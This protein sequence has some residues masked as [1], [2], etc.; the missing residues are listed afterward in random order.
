MKIIK[1]AEGLALKVNL[2]K[3]SN[4]TGRLYSNSVNLVQ[5]ESYESYITFDFL[6]ERDFSSPG[7]QITLYSQWTAI[8][9]L[10]IE[11]GIEVLED[12]PTQW[13]S[14]VT[15]ST[16]EENLNDQL[17]SLQ[18]TLAFFFPQT[19]HVERLIS[20]EKKKRIIRD[21]ENKIEGMGQD[22]E[23][24]HSPSMDYEVARQE[25]VDSQY[26]KLVDGLN[27]VRYDRALLRTDASQT[28]RDTY[29]EVT[30]EKWLEAEKVI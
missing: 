17:T 11:N 13:D 12:D 2:L 15:L 20:N 10:L 1:M 5:A 23:W 30:D 26:H 24:A 3:V 29:P 18:R 28:T 27:S 21:L 6:V 7:Y 9:E 19:F 25:E 4:S 22:H 14:K 8:H 16:R